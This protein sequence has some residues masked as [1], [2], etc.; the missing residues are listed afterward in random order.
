[1][2]PF[3]FSKTIE[4]PLAGETAESALGAI[5]SLLS[6]RIKAEI[7]RSFSSNLQQITFSGGVFRFVGNWNL[8]IWITYGVIDFMPVNDKLLIS[9]KLSFL[10]LFLW[11]SFGTA[12]LGFCVF[13]SEF[14]L[15]NFS[16]V[17][18]MWIWFF[19]PAYIM[20]AVR[21]HNIIKWALGK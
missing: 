20:T 6:R 11:T 21:F 16:L 13:S 3:T 15:Q 14:T 17:A 12:L 19:V 2:F 9:Y 5:V 18:A 1:M 4:I 10:E 7:P 8:L